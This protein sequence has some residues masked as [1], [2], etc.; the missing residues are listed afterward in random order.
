MRTLAIAGG[1][2]L[3]EEE[4]GNFGS[5]DRVGPTSRLLKKGFMV[6]SGLFYP[7]CFLA[8]VLTL[9]SPILSRSPC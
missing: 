3:S 5:T 7:L 6:V 9:H 4:I 1:E 8:D 2:F